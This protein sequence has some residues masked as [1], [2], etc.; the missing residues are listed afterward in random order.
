MKG[1]VTSLIV[2]GNKMTAHFQGRWPASR[3]RAS[4][5]STSAR[6]A[7]GKYNWKGQRRGQRYA[8]QVRVIDVVGVTKTYGATTA[9]DDVG[10]SAAGWSDLPARP[11]RRGED[12]GDD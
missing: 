1:D 2:D 7:C 5:T 3:L 6:A 11:E 12:D 9:V 8:R 4:L 10:S